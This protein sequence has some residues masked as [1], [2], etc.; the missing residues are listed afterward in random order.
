MDNLLYSLYLPW[1]N[2]INNSGELLMKIT[3]RGIEL[4]KLKEWA[5]FCKIV[6]S[7]EKINVDNEVF[8]VTYD[9]YYATMFVGG[10]HINLVNRAGDTFELKN[11]EYEC[12]TIE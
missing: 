11:N 4:A 2:N 12:V 9:S 3:I 8:D 10:Q 5:K 7:S 1:H 6:E